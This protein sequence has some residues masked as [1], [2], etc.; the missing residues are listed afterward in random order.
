MCSN[1][2]NKTL[3][4]A[5]YGQGSS[6]E[7]VTESKIRAAEQVVNANTG[8]APTDTTGGKEENTSGVKMKL[9]KKK[10]AYV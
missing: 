8:N 6:N 2:Y 3:A 5:V 7:D 1:P 10:G 9:R 4:R